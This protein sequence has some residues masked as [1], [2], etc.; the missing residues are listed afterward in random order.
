[1]VGLTYESPS[2]KEGRYCRGKKYWLTK[3][4]IEKV[5]EDKLIPFDL[6][7]EAIPLMD[8]PFD[9][10]NLDEF[11]Y[12]C[13]RVEDTSLDYPIIL[14]DYGQIADGN[15]RVVKAILQGKKSIK[16]V[17]LFTMPQSYED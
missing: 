17:R 2:Y 4:L 14:D 3:D 15:H 10:N 11:I 6:P 5:K 9:L 12:H 1:M 16:A 13:K 7:V 8:L